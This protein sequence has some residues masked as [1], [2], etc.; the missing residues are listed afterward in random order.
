MNE[1]PA[2]HQAV[3][4]QR[5]AADPAQSAMVAAN[6]GS[7][8]TRV[9]T[10]RVA[11]LLLNGAAPDRILCITY[12]KA[13]AAEMAHRLFELLGAWALADDDTLT[14]K[15]NALEGADNTQRAPRELARARKLFARALETPGGLKIQTIHSFCE[16]VL[17]RFPLEAGA[18]P[19]FSVLDEREAKALA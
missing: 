15:L 9:L 4:A 14:E 2:F 12:T 8:K 5:R 19:G 11:R 7:G 16:N 18:P 13:A 10:D 6:A 3:K 1:P 17:K